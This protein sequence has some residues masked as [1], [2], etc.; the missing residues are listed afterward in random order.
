MC[1]TP[2]K[3]EI[4]NLI[5]SKNRD[6]MPKSKKA[7][8]AEQAEAAIEEALTR[9]E[10]AILNSETQGHESTSEQATYIEQ[11]EI[12]NKQMAREHDEMKKHCIGLKNGY[13]ALEEKCR[14][15]ENANESAEKE[16]TNTLHDLD[17][18]IAQ[19]SLH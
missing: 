16:L 7:M 18:I 14:R 1:L 4:G 9:L 12:E 17:Q 11:L 6:I 3:K 19:K 8:S 10:R 15:L 5:N 13:E 2:M